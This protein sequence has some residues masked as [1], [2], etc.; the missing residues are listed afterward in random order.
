MG[1]WLDWPWSQLIDVPHPTFLTDRQCCTSPSENKGLL[2]PSKDNDDLFQIQ[3]RLMTKSIQTGLKQV[4]E[5]WRLSTAAAVL[6]VK[7]RLKSQF[8]QRVYLRSKQIVI[9]QWG[10]CAEWDQSEL[11]LLPWC[12]AEISFTVALL[13]NSLQNSRGEV[14]L[15]T[16][17]SYSWSK[18]Y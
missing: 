1:G 10:F 3:N 14:L 12:R 16:R 2:Q 5:S 17:Q 4:P 8:T 9:V 6:Q 18:V 11:Q 13:G 7:A 15:D